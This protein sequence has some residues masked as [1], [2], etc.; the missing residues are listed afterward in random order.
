M[1]KDSESLSTENERVRE[2][3]ERRERGRRRQDGGQRDGV[4]GYTTHQWISCS[5]GRLLMLLIRHQ[6]LVLPLWIRHEKGQ[7]AFNKN[8][9][10]GL[11]GLSLLWGKL[12]VL[13]NPTTNRLHFSQ[14]T[15]HS[16]SPDILVITYSSKKSNSFLILKRL[17]VA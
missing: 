17:L 13:S 6:I 3:G 4:V 9:L 10:P 16:Q 2:V 1:V 5:F 14:W 8:D 11:S 12:V 15:E 7:H